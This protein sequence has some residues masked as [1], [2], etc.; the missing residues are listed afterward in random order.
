MLHVPDLIIQTLLDEEYRFEACFVVYSSPVT[1]RMI[2]KAY[3]ASCLIS[4]KVLYTFT[5]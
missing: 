5:V 4:K 1:F 2:L 3:L